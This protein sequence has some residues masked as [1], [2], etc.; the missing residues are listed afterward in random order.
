MLEIYV[1]IRLTTV[2][3]TATGVILQPLYL[4]IVLLEQYEIHSFAFIISLDPKVVKELP[5]K[6]EMLIIYIFELVS[7]LLN[8]SCG[9]I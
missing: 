8:A 7:N 1:K 3:S 2:S 6:Y 4:Y 9:C 5:R